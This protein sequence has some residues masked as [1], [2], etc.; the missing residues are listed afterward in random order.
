MRC[1]S[2]FLL[3][4]DI[5]RWSFRQTYGSF[6]KRFI[7]ECVVYLVLPTAFYP[8][9]NIFL[10]QISNLRNGV[11]FGIIFENHTID[12]VLRSPEPSFFLIF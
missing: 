3:V 5:S 9:K 1:F 7:A 10:W 6:C 4:F 11:I 12:F 2:C 8:R